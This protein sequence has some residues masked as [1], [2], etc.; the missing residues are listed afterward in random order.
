M[1][2][3]W[4][5]NGGG[6]QAARPTELLHMQKRRWA[7]PTTRQKVA[8]PKKVKGSGSRAIGGRGYGPQNQISN[9]SRGVTDRTELPLGATDRTEPRA[10]ERSLPRAS[11]FFCPLFFL[12]NKIFS[13][14]IYVYNL[15]LHKKYV[16]NSSFTEKLC[17]QLVVREKIIH[18]S[19]TSNS[20][21]YKL[22]V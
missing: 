8:S 1:I 4:E 7:S 10:R 18:S 16:H 12:F 5:M 20:C 15:P 3:P 2:R 13:Y 11:F 21:A 19:Y 22:Y 9:R 14:I 6:Q 17:T